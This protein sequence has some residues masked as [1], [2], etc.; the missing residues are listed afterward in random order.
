[1]AAAATLP[2]SSAFLISAALTLLASA[3]APAR[4]Q[5]TSSGHP[6]APVPIDFVPESFSFRA[7]V[8]ALSPAPADADSNKTVRTLLEWGWGKKAGE[9]RGY[10]WGEYLNFTRNVTGSSWA[11]SYPNNYGLPKQFNRGGPPWTPKFEDTILVTHLFVCHLGEFPCN[12][13]RYPN[14]TCTLD[15][16]QTTTIELQVELEGKSFELSA[17]LEWGAEEGSCDDLGIVV[18]QTS[19]TGAHFVET[20][21][22][23]NA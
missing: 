6:G 22:Q 12:L 20:F 4:E 15:A 5:L 14:S 8:A 21:Q 10:G 16:N 18:G 19:S 7:R 9:T 11:K 3:P 17:R 1:M 23:Y 13:K 2:R